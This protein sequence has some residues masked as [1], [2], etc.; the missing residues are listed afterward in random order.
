MQILVFLLFYV[1]NLHVNCLLEKLE[2]NE[3][4]VENCLQI[5]H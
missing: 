1:L 4:H 2:I 3:H 5:I